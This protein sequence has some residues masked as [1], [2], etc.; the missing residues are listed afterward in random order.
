M[1]FRFKNP[2]LRRD[3]RSRYT[4]KQSRHVLAI[5]Y[6]VCCLNRYYNKRDRYRFHRPV[7]TFE[8]R[9]CTKRCLDKNCTSCTHDATGPSCS[10]CSCKVQLHVVAAPLCLQPARIYQQLMALV[11]T[12][13]T[14]FLISPRPRCRVFR[15][16]RRFWF[17]A[18]RVYRNKFEIFAFNHSY[19]LYA[20]ARKFIRTEFVWNGHRGQLVLFLRS[21]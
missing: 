15:F 20:L 6:F 19:N 10:S 17:I 2:C 16:N 18:L 3:P 13:R 1:T 7:L 12:A 4:A 11:R 21:V 8:S 5:K 14:A 9:V